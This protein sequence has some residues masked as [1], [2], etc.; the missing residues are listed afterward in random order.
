MSLQEII[1]LEELKKD[2]VVTRAILECAKKLLELDEDKGVHLKVD[3]PNE[4][5]IHEDVRVSETLPTTN[6]EER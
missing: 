1:E 3:D 4:T 2:T 6:C 5:G